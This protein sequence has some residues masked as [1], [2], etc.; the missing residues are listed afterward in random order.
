MQTTGIL[1]YRYTLAAAPDSYH[2]CQYYTGARA[3][4]NAVFGRGTGRIWLDDVNC[5]GTERRLIDCPD[6]GFGV[7]NCRHHEDAGVTCQPSS[8]LYL[9]DDDC[10]AMHADCNVS[11]FVLGVQITWK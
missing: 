3:R 9:N 8:V 6:N 10:K 2:T 7:H 11:I 5:R 4:S 1:Y